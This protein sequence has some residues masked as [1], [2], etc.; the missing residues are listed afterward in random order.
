MSVW[1]Q[2]KAPRGPNTQSLN[3]NLN[4]ILSSE[5]LNNIMN[6]ITEESSVLL[7]F[8]F[9]FPKKGTAKEEEDPLE[10]GSQ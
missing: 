3:N 6:W 2:L 9:S 8:L 1:E 10:G 7:L 4:R 5:Q